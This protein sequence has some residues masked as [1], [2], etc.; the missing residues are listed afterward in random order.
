MGINF[1]IKKLYG[2]KKMIIK[3]NIYKINEIK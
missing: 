3:F 2:L 1:I